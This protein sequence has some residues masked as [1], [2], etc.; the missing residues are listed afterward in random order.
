M[1]EDQ[2]CDSIFQWHNLFLSYVERKRSEHEKAEIGSLKALSRFQKPSV[3]ADTPGVKKETQQKQKE[4]DNQR[5]SFFSSRKS[6]RH[7]AEFKAWQMIL[8]V[9]QLPH[10]SRS[11]AP[12]QKAGNGSA[13][14]TLQLWSKQRQVDLP[15]ALLSQ[16]N[17]SGSAE[18]SKK[19]CFKQ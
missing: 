6:F 4:K 12:T 16:P 19:P 9:Q 14:C 18:L 1:E 10:R 15:S 11:L 8:L 3:Y 7:K 13:V 2:H 17:Q 5:P